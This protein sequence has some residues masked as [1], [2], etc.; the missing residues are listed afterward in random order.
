MKKKVLSALLV[1]AMTASMV[2]CGASEGTN[3]NDTPAADNNTNADA[4]A[5]N[6]ADAPADNA[7]DAPAD[8]TADAA[9]PIANL[10]AATTDTVSLTLWC[11][12][13]ENWQNAMASI[14]EEFKAQYPDVTF[15]IS[16]GAES[17]ANAKDDLLNDVEAGADVFVFADDQVNEL[18]T[19]G[20]LNPVQTTFTYDLNT[21]YSD[22]TL[23]AASVGDQLYAYP[24]IASNGYFLFYDSNYVTAEQ[25]GSWEG[26][27]EAAKACDG[28][29]GM[30]FGNAWY[31]YSFF[32]G[33]GCQATLADD[34]INTV[35]DW[36]SA[37]GVDVANAIMEIASNDC[38][39][40]VGDQDARKMEVNGKHMIAYVDGTWA[41]SD[42]ENALG[43]GYAATKLP[44]FTVGGQA[45]QMGSFSG[46][47]LVGVNAYSKNTGWAMVLA[48]YL[49]SAETQVKLYEA[50]G[51]GPAN[52][53]AAALASS[54]ALEAL[55]AQS[56]Y[57][58]L[59]R[60]G[61]NFWTPGNSLGASLFEG[62]VADV[63]ALLDEAVA[64][65]TA[66][67]Q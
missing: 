32:A 26:L 43:N 39:L 2:A 67:V 63:Q 22:A 49:T 35:C 13:Q 19:A 24:L 8:D 62:G 4:P 18:V 59:Q 50:T 44:T 54:P 64:G 52:I 45:V 1:A 51:E 9:D 23:E 10:I 53:D 21:A 37:T 27:I 5:D 33:A 66:P 11:S 65:I 47:K 14:V 3:N 30:D 56:P 7:T 55:L 29:I 36:N 15:D 28:V 20:A 41:A 12:E 40:S 17:E 42:I 60:V 58:D 48:E 61:G 34:G 6:T 46:Y 38:V 31:L 16:I 25:A 57:A